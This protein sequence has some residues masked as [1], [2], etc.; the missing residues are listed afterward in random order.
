MLTETGRLVVVVKDTDVPMLV[1]MLGVRETAV[2]VFDR[3]G[4]LEMRI[5][6][7]RDII[8]FDLR[9]MLALAESASPWGRDT[10]PSDAQRR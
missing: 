4:V 8:S 7:T 5:S 2:E 1:G 3:P 6:G 10:K 9:D